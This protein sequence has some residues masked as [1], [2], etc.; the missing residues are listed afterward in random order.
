MARKK[1]RKKARRRVRAAVRKVSHKIPDSVVNH[2]SHYQGL[3]GKVE[4]VD[5]IEE[6]G[7]TDA[8]IAHVL[9]YILRAGRKKSSSYTEDLAKARWWINRAIAFHGG[10]AE[11]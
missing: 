10:H 2:P 6:F 4:A 3:T 9:T 1:V 11:D 5:V 8:H 7:V